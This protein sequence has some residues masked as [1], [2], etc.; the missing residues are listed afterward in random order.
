[1]ISI[2]SLSSVR[3]A[4]Q[5]GSAI[6]HRLSQRRAVD[7]EDHALMLHL[8]PLHELPDHL[9]LRFFTGVGVRFPI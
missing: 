8:D 3:L 1:V 6:S 7:G 9:E 5:S 4:T 2:G